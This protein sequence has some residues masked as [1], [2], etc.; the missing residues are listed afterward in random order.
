MDNLNC[1]STVLFTHEEDLNLSI[2]Q[3]KNLFIL[4]TNNL[5]DKLYK[6]LTTEKFK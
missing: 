5:L 4:F 2:W 3:I 6:N 1:L